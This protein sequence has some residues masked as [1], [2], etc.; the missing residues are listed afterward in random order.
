MGYL[1]MHP[2]YIQ[3][4]CIA[5]IATCKQRLRERILWRRPARLRRAWL[6]GF[7]IDEPAQIL[8]S[9]LCILVRRPILR[10]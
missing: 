3:S 7:V 10:V 4:I 1:S 2:P 9:A 5:A 6:L 8:V